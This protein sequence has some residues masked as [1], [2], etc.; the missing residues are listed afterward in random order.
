M[1]SRRI[2]CL[3]FVPLH[4]FRRRLVFLRSE[5]VHARSLLRSVRT[6]GLVFL[7]AMVFVG[8]LHR[9]VTLFCLRD[10]VLNTDPPPRP[11]SPKN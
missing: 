7:T 9:H 10:K 11:V 6:R 2:L 4:K 5:A 3:P 1:W 8:P